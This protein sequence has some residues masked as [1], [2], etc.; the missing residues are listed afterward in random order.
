MN[1]SRNEILTATETILS[2]DRRGAK[3][4]VRPMYLDEVKNLTRGARVLVHTGYHGRYRHSGLVTVTVN[5][6]PKTWKTRP[7]DVT[8]PV[9]YGLYECTHVDYRDGAMSDT[10]LYFVVELDD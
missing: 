9:K 10:A 1:E 4:Q 8:V 6:R 3:I 7:D 2:G 5:G